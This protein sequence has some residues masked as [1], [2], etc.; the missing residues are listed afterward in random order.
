MKKQSPKTKRLNEV[1]R[2]HLK[3]VKRKQLN[4]IKKSIRKFQR[5]NESKYT[6]LVDS[7]N[8]KGYDLD[9]DYG[10]IETIM[11]KYGKTAHDLEDWLGGRDANV[12][13]TDAEVE[14]WLGD[15]K[16]N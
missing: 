5:L 1:K 16:S 15:L 3:T 7:G 10:A 2:K 8:S 13:P 4:E 12:K 9:F 14:R 11:G 6:K